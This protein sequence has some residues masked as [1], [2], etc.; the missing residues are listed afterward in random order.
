MVFSSSPGID[1]APR[2]AFG[3]LP[4]SPSP[5]LM[6]DGLTNA[7]AVLGVSSEVHLEL[8]R[9]SDGLKS[10]VLQALAASL[11][12]GRLAAAQEMATQMAQLQ[13]VNA[14]QATLLMQQQDAIAASQA[15]LV[16]AKTSSDRHMEDA[17]KAK[18]ELGKRKAELDEL[19]AQLDV[20]TSRSQRKFTLTASSHAGDCDR[21]VRSTIVFLFQLHATIA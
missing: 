10:F 20:K 19:Q 8:S 7:N 16:V 11:E 21:N 9:A 5:A 12:A 2:D 3:T 1:P 18:S 13:Q 6:K 15:A 17:E 14:A 4:A